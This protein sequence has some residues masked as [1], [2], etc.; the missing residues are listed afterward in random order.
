MRFVFVASVW[1]SSSLG[2]SQSLPGPDN[3]FASIGSG[4][5]SAA[6]F[7]QVEIRATYNVPAYQ[8]KLEAYLKSLGFQASAAPQ[9]YTFSDGKWFVGQ[10]DG[11]PIFSLWITERGVRNWTLVAGT[12]VWKEEANDDQD[13]RIRK[14]ATALQ[15][16]YEK[17]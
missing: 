7:F 6:A 14:L 12:I 2:F 13:I 8:K 5:S 10:F 4:P 3:A 1:F 9:G 16:L 17:K 15:E 11:S